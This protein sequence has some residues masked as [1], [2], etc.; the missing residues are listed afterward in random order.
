MAK[1]ERANR[2]KSSGDLRGKTAL[3]TGAGRGIGRAI[4]SALARDGARVVCVG[5]REKLVRATVASIERSGGAASA[6]AH[7]ITAPDFLDVLSSRAPRIDVLVHNAAAFAPYAH[8]EH[9]DDPAIDRVLATCLRAPLA[10]TR[11]L[12]GGMKQRGFGR[13]VAIGTIAA[14]HGA[15]GQ[16]AYAT[17]KSGLRGFVCSVAAESAAHGVT[18][19]LV[20]P[21]LIATERIAEAVGLEWQ[22]KLLANTAMMR[23]GKPEEVAELVAFLC[24]PRASYI[25]GAV[26]PVSGGFGVGLYARD[27]PGRK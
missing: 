5:R 2:G 24:S 17:A 22:R 1:S 6:L 15:E 13:I 20:E 12:I 10:I 11:A 26:I 8:L 7:D 3:V 25:T 21:G 23:A 19:N 4:A 14:E 9:V 27:L 16:V 18:A